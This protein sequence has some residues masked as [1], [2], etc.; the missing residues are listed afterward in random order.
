MYAYFA[1]WLWGAESEE[2]SA[3]LPRF[4]DKPISDETFQHYNNMQII[5]FCCDQF[6]FIFPIRRDKFIANAPTC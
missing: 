4:C 2:I 3:E 1:V 6:N 5:E